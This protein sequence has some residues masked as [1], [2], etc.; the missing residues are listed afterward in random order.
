MNK[1]THD[2][3]HYEQEKAQDEYLDSLE[4]RWVTV[5]M[6]ADILIMS[7]YDELADDD[8]VKERV[9]DELARE[10]RAYEFENIVLNEVYQ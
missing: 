2:N 8:L 10:C 6:T 5:T 9:L 1:M 3:A 4:P 7:T